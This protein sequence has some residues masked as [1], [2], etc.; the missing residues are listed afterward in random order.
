M[1]RIFTLKNKMSIRGQS[2]IELALAFPIA[3]ALLFL[4]IRGFQA[5]DRASQ[6]STQGHYKTLNDFNLGNGTLKLGSGEFQNGQFIDFSGLTPDIKIGREILDQLKTSSAQLGF[7]FLLDKLKFL[8]GKTYLSSGLKAG[9]KY[10]GHTLIS[11][12]FDI[13]KVDPGKVAW[14]VAA[15]ALASEQA[16]KDFQGTDAS[17]F[18]EA[19][20]STL[21]SGFTSYAQNFGDTK[22]LASGSLGGLM[23]SQTVAGLEDSQWDILSGAAKGALQSSLQGALDK[24]FNIENVLISSGAGA[25]STKTV[26]EAL[27]FT[28]WGGDARQSAMAQATYVALSGVMQEA[29]L[30]DILLGSASGAMMSSQT[31]TATSQ[32][33]ILGTGIDLTFGAAVGLLAQKK[34][35][36]TVAVSAA[37]ST[38]QG[39]GIPT[40]TGQSASGS[41]KTEA[42]KQQEEDNASKTPITWTKNPFAKFLSL[43]KKKAP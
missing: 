35:A 29:S 30:R 27:P 33:K 7:N 43:F 40:L 9:V 16:T 11:A 5:N 1:A 23:G 21:Q 15:G 3:L 34:D 6:T 12:D 25:L 22:A 32:N 31:Q 24:N 10:T 37:Q 19:A 28:K 20:G 26:A 42:E 18:R 2:A 14:S 4:I 38:L 39:T 36:K 17:S 41:Q 13:S 8:N